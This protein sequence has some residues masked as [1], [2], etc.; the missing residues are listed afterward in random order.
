MYPDSP[1]TDT[2]DTKL[3]YEAENDSSRS[4]STDID[5]NFKE[6]FKWLC[7]APK[8]SSFRIN[9]LKTSKQAV[10]ESLKQYLNTGEG[11]A[12]ANCILHERVE[13]TL[14]I[15]FSP[16]SSINVHPK[17][18]VV[19]KDCGAAV[20]RGA[21][22]FAPGVL[23]MVSGCQI[24]DEVSIYVDIMKTCKR[25]LQK[26]FTGS[27]LHIGNGIVRM[28]RSELYGADL[29]PRG[30]AVEVTETISG[31]PQIS[32]DLFPPGKIL[33]QNLPSIICVHTLDPQPNE[34]I[35]DMCAAPGHKTS[36]I[37]SLMTNQGILIAIDKTAGKTKLL[38]E[39]CLRFDAKPQIYV[40]DSSKIFSSSS[41][42]K[43]LDG[44]PYPANSFDRILLDAPCSAL[45]KRPQLRNDITNKVLKSYV[46]LQKKLFVVAVNL[47]KSNGI[48]VYSTC[49]ITLSEN[50]GIVA[51]ALRKFDLELVQP[52]VHIGSPGFE[53][54]SLT[55]EQLHLVQRF[56]PETGIDSIGFFIACFRKKLIS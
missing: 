45:G 21:H 53:G 36:H 5:S 14:I 25:G 41:T 56:G 9:T 40:A 20:L 43:P 55:K 39:H 50:E 32:E 42:N 51:W 54:T 26:L 37:A 48:L 44:P 27:K 30:V 15:Q 2:L 16:I 34:V 31:C 52:K 17:E 18:V 47:L 22:I 49:T 29:N 19:D 33:L 46:A 6:I 23:G 3:V 4:S 28:Q 8:I 10:L 11:K 7:T 12:T 13:D 1:F 35:L 24:G 38:A